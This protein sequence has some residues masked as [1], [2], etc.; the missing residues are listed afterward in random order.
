MTPV[1]PA[2]APMPALPFAAVLFDCDG[3][4]VDSEPITLGVMRDVFA[5]HGWEMSQAECTARFLG[6]QLSDDAADIERHT[7]VPFPRL[8]AAFRARRDAALAAR[9]R[10]IDGIAEV[11]PVLYRAYGGRIACASGS[12][13]GKL[14]VMLGTA[15]LA[16]WFEGGRLLSGTEMPR[17]K[18]APDVYLAAAAALGVAAADCAV[19]EDTRTGATAGLTAGATV[20]GYCPGGPGHD[21]ARQLREA[22]VRHLFHD[23]RQLPA[24]L[25]VAG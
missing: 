24:L 14:D 19:V 23:M 1:A 9:V 6:R 8:Q 5:E 16:R 18:P 20:F 15:G 25:G 21:S 12:D 11:L 4:L 17:G 13:R 10:P 22:G 2:A 7:G 3:V